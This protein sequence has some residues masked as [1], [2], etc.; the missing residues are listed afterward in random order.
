ME[1]VEEPGDA[2]LRR[3]ITALLEAAGRHQTA[4]SLD[5]LVELLPATAP[6]TPEALRDWVQANP[7]H[8]VLIDQRV[9]APGAVPPPREAGEARRQ[10]GASYLTAAQR[11]FEG[12]LWSFRHALVCAAVTGSTAYREPESGDDLDLM[13]VT[14]PGGTW[15]FIALAF[16][17]IRLRQSA[18]APSESEWCF[19]FVL[20]A[21]E[22]E[23][24]YHEP[25]GFLFAREALT[26]RP[27]FGE[28]YY[29]G[30]INSAPWMRDDFP[31]LYARWQA[32]APVAPA[33]GE[34]LPLVVRAANAFLFPFVAAY[35]QLR[36]LRRNREHRRGG[37]PDR[38]FSTVTRLRKYALYSDEFRRLSELYEA[39]SPSAGGGPSQWGR[40]TG[41][42]TSGSPAE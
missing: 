41:S 10:L 17:L 25:R 9:A 24:D 31:R 5:E 32:T 19:N 15:L 36:G 34:P 8:A 23:H 35:L 33:A 16:A 37:R 14:R 4:V 13:V 26:A 11:L 21:G 2:E 29:R 1:G 38:G 18:R 3:R 22:I 28:E 40:P 30:L 12:P 6:P 42:R 20:E 39:P 7:E 27:L